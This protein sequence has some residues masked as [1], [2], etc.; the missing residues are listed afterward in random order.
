[1]QREPSDPLTR[2]MLHSDV[3]SSCVRFDSGSSQVRGFSARGFLGF[4]GEHL[5]MS[6]A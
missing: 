5:G 6:N 4:T 3:G 1:M 2:K